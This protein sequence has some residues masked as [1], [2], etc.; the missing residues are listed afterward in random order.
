MNKANLEIAKKENSVIF[1]EENYK[2]KYNGFDPNSPESL[3]GL[4]LMQEDYLDQSILLASYVQDNFVHKLKRK[5][6][7][8]KQAGFW[9]LHNTYM[10]SILVETGFLTNK[11]EGEYLNSKKGQSEMAKS[12]KDGV[13]SYKNNLSIELNKVIV[14]DGIIDSD[15]TLSDII[16][17]IQ[18]AAGS[19]K[20]E[21]KPYNFNGLK[22]VSSESIGNGYKYFYGE[23]SNYE[24]AKKYREEAREK[25]YSSCFIVAYKKGKRIN[26][27]DALKT[28]SN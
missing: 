22:G 2:E 16:F 17:K 10:P 20:L 13:L 23:T 25:G 5:N 26:V 11:K 24:E 12:I 15:E 27:S 3:I 14:D 1:L 21:T 7:G 18:I 9:V 4:T 8:V 28:V 6:R 19:R